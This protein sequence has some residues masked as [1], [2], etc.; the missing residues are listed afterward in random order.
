MSA[1][2]QQGSTIL[3]VSLKIDAF[4]RDETSAPALETAQTAAR[5]EGQ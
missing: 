1:A 3:T 5:G 4:I 2:P